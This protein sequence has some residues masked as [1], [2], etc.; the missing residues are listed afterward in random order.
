MNHCYLCHKSLKPA[1]VGSSVAF[2]YATFPVCKD[3]TEAETHE[4]II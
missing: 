1:D 3:C 4:V 2:N